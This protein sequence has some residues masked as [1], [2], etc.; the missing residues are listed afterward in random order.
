MRS[1]YLKDKTGSQYDYLIQLK[2]GTNAEY[3]QL[4]G[5]SANYDAFVVKSG[6]PEY[7]TIILNLSNTTAIQELFVV[8]NSKL[9]RIQELYCVYELNN[10]DLDQSQKKR[11]TGCLRPEESEDYF[12]L[13]SLWLYRKLPSDTA[14]LLPLFCDGVELQ[15]ASG[16]RIGFKVR[17]E[18]NLQTLGSSD[19]ILIHLSGYLEEPHFD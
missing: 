14:N 2:D 11:I 7:K 4:A 1:I 9:F 17:D 5:S 12:D 16:S 13:G 18:Q 10:L 19:R 6:V 15:L 3:I 8:P